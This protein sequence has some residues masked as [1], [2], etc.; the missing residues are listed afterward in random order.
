[1]SF[2]KEHIDAVS[3]RL[4]LYEKVLEPGKPF[5]RLPSCHACETASHC[6]ECLFCTDRG[7]EVPYDTP[8][9]GRESCFSP[10]LMDTGAY[11]ETKAEQRRQFRHLLRIVRLNGYDF[12]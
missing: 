5:Q 1:M 7:A 11:C 3:A 12:T 10:T 6:G 4:R 2:T 9:G 8:R